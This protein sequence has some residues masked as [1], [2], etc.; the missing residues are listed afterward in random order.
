MLA[1]SSLAAPWLL[2]W[3]LSIPVSSC[4][5]ESSL[6]VLSSWCGG[7]EKRHLEVM[8]GVKVLWDTGRK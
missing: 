2:Q 4:K 6:L 8:Q 7:G 5:E 1:S 3:D